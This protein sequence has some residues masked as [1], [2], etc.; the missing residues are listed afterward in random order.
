VKEGIPQLLR[1]LFLKQAWSRIIAD[2]DSSWIDRE[3]D[4]GQQY[5]NRPYAGLGLALA[6][7]L[8]KGASREDLSEIARCIQAQTLFDVGYLIDGPAYGVPGLEGLMWGLFQTDED[9]KPFGPQIGGLHESV[10]ELD[11]TGREMRPKEN[12]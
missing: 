12:G 6:R 4:N 7:C 8:D 10:L 3:I 2:G 5:P 11:P 1:Y 9:G